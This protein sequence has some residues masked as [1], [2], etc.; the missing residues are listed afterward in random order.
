MFKQKQ[1]KKYFSILKIALLIFC[2]GVMMTYAVTPK[3][4]EGRI[5]SAQKQQ[6]EI[7]IN[8]QRIRTEK[9]L[10]QQEVEVLQTKI[11]AYNEEIRLDKEEWQRLERVVD[12]SKELLDIENGVLSPSITKIGASEGVQELV[13]YAYSK[14]GLD[15]VLT[16]DAENG[17]WQI[18]RKSNIVGANG[19][20][21]FGLCQLN[22]KYHE[23]FIRSAEF[24]NGNAQIDYCAGVWDNAMKRG[25]IRTTF[26][27]YNTRHNNLKNFKI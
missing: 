4:L 27:G 12:L 23:P 6:M 22:M 11:N 3:G 21:D 14:R 5:K 17:L 10:V 2:S 18:D 13:R 8:A 16:L 7:H 19:Y 15:F 20:S 26:Y 9:G 25:I 24:K 1:I